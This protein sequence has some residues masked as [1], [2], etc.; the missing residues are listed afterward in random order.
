MKCTRERNDR[1][2]RDGE[3][4]RNSARVCLWGWWWWRNAELNATSKQIKHLRRGLKRV[5]VPRRSIF[6]TRCETSSGI[7]ARCRGNTRRRPVPLFQRF[8]AARAFSFFP[9]SFFLLS[10]SLIFFLFLFLFFRSE[11]NRRSTGTRRPSPIQF[12]AR[13]A[14]STTR[15]LAL[16][17][18]LVNFH[19]IT[20]MF[21][22]DYPPVMENFH[23][24]N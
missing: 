17:H 22:L 1:E 13:S 14:F 10:S 4:E 23:R 20:G 2:K 24:G 5:D 7:N 9:L 11:L 3:T 18:L 21:T 19:R 12:R 8:S 6:A 15:S 16:V